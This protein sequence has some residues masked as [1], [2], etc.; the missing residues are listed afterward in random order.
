MLSAAG[1]NCKKHSTEVKV[2]SEEGI[3]LEEKEK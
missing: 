1:L 2:P 3:Y